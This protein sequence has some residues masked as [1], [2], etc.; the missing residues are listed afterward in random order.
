VG[1]PGPALWKQWPSSGILFSP[2]L[3]Y[4][5]LSN[6]VLQGHRSQGLRPD[7]EFFFERNLL[8]TV[9]CPLPDFPVVKVLSGFALTEGFFLQD[10]SFVG[11]IRRPPPLQLPTLSC[12]P[13]LP[14]TRRS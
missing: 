10:I 8:K 1:F 13:Q 12:S 2:V 7:D 6:L 14:R 9:H 3:A 4:P 5:P 11:L